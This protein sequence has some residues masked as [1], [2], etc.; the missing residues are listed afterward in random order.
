MS[1]V[2]KSPWS[3]NALAQRLQSTGECE[4]VITEA[5]FY[6]NAGRTVRRQLR[7]GRSPQAIARVLQMSVSEALD[8]LR[9]AESSPALLLR[10]L[11]EAW[12][13]ERIKQNLRDWPKPGRAANP[14]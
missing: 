12:S 8:A 13:W 9:F 11:L 7:H 5:E 2:N 4:A 3:R 6:L 1:H 10:A 14:R